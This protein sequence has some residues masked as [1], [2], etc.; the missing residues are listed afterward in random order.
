MYIQFVPAMPKLFSKAKKD[1]CLL[2]FK[3]NFT[4]SLSVTH[5]EVIYQWPANR[6]I[7]RTSPQ[8]VNLPK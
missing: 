2:T 4:S 7:L 5:T 1:T 8:Q 6:L 3:P